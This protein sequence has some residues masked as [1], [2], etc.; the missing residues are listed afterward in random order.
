MNWLT[1]PQLKLADDVFV[2][3]MPTAGPRPQEWF[4]GLGPAIVGLAS[5]ETVERFGAPA[6]RIEAARAAYRNGEEQGFK[7]GY[8]SGMHWGLLTGAIAGA[9]LV[10]LLMWAGHFVWPHLIA[11][12]FGR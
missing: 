6:R 12:W 8:V 1:R 7:S 9:L 3:D 4:S 2:S 11:A 10:C 5:A